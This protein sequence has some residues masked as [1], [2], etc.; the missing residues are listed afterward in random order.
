MERIS[1]FVYFSKIAPDAE[2]SCVADII[3]VA[4][5][6]NKEHQIT[7]MLIFDG[8]RFCQ[9]IEGPHEPLQQL[10]A[11]ITKDPRHIEFTP[12]LACFDQKTRLFPNWSM[13]YVI[14]DDSEP[15]DEVESMEGSSMLDK[16]HALLPILDAA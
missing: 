13:A 11:S 16:L 15:L 4:R 7:G 12:K 5:K 3:K 10:I 8:L 9:Y 2:V 1:N 14:A 6:F